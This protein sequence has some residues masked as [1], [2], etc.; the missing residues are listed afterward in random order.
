MHRAL[1]NI[2]SYMSHQLA[3]GFPF[4]DSEDSEG[5]WEKFGA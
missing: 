3:E 4:Q 1:H 2:D 5:L